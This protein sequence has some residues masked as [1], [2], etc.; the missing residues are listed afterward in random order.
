MT[1]GGDDRAGVW[2]HNS[3]GVIRRGDDRRGVMTGDD[4]SRG[5]MAE[6]GGDDRAGG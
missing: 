3:Q 1:G 5:V 6:Q 2:W 4:D